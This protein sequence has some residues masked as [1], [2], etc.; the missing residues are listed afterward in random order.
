MTIF[1]ELLRAVFSDSKSCMHSYAGQT[2]FKPSFK[3]VKISLKNQC[4]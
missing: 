2:G 1:L 3:I 4:F